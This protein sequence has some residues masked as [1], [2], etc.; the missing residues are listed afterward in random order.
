[1]EIAKRGW[2]SNLSRR[3]KQ[4]LLLSLASLVIALGSATTYY[5]WP[6]TGVYEYVA[7]RDR[8]MILDIFAQDWYWLV[9][10]DR[11]SFSPERMLDTKSPNK[12]PE[13]QGVEHVKVYL[14]AGQP[15]GFVAFYKKKFYEGFLHL[16]GLQATARGKGY[17]TQLMRTALDALFA[18]PAIMYIKLVTR[19]N[20]T[21]AI[22]VYERLGFKRA[23][24][25]GDFVYFR[26]QR[27]DYR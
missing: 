19:M 2:W 15:V 13:Y 18:D 21:A 27:A 20:N 11:N 17:A 9:A 7:A 16:L 6:K 8:Q 25:D 3:A 23:E 4:V 10:G 26:L 14:V 1:M 22:K 24:L 5:F 12:N